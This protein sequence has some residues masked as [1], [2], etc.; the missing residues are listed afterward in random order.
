MTDWSALLPTDLAQK[1]TAYERKQCVLRMRKSGVTFREIAGRLGISNARASEICAG[2]V[3]QSHSPIAAYCDEARTMS[4]L[5]VM[6]ADYE[7]RVRS[8]HVR[9]GVWPTPE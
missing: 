7:A 4:A 3:K 1:Q 5:H 9:L 8:G 2:A 6:F